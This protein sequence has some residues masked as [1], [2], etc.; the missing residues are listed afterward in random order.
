M[1]YFWKCRC[2]APE[3]LA[4]QGERTLSVGETIDL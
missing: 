4:E 1:T 3:S 2:L